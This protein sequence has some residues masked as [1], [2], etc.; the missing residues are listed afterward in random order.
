MH[1]ACLAVWS[2]VTQSHWMMTCDSSEQPDAPTDL[3]LTDPEARSVQLTWTPGDDHN[4]PITSTSPLSHGGFIRQCWVR[5]FTT[6]N[7]NTC[8]SVSRVPD[9]VWRWS[10]SRWSVAQSHWGSWDEDHRSSKTLA[11]RPLHF[12]SAGGQ[13]RGSQPSQR[14]HP[15]VQNQPSRF[16]PALYIHTYIQSESVFFLMVVVLLG[17]FSSWWEPR[18]C[19]SHGH[20][21]QQSGHIMEG[22][23]GTICIKFVNNKQ[24]MASISSF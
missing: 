19:Q 13:W 1:A 21:T 5:Y 9:S 3:E 22:K 8:V 7:H 23:T 6:C 2:V 12:Q 14:A 20:G 24:N 4:S 11:V 15:T 17:P 16:G 18:W 10:S